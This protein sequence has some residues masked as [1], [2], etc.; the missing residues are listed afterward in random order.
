MIEF[1]RG[2][3]NHLSAVRSGEC[4]MYPSDSKYSLQ[5]IQKHGMFVGWIMAMDRLMRCGRDETR[6]SP[7]IIINGKSKYYDPVEKNDFWWSD[8]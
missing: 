6:L 2:P 5:S 4:P 7:K 8:K 3:L 1:Y